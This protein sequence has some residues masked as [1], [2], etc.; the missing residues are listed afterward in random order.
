MR[1]VGATD[2]LCTISD[3]MQTE[4]EQLRKKVADLEMKSARQAH[5]V[6]IALGFFVLAIVTFCYS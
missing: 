5:D 6:C 4:V 3:A 1:C 2:R